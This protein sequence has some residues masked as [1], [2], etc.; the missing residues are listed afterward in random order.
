MC[1]RFARATDGGWRGGDFAVI[2]AHNR[3]M[4]TH[5][6]QQ[7]HA[8]RRAE[9][10]GAL[11]VAIDLGL[12]QPAEHMLRSVLIA[13]RL[14]E[15]ID[16]DTETRD[17]LYYTCLLMWIGCHA[18]SQEYARWF[19][20]DIAVR[21]DAYL[22][23]WSGLPF[24]GF[25][26]RN[27]GRNEPLA[28][29]AKTIA[30]FIGDARGHMAE[31]IHSH[32]ASA[33]L[34]AAHI[35]LPAS[36][37]HALGFTFERFDGRGLPAGVQG[38]QI[39]LAMRI[40]QLA[41]VCEVHLRRAGIPGVLELLH[42]R[43]GGQLDPDL[44]EAALSDPAGLFEQLDDPGLWEQVMELAP[45]ST[46]ELASDEFEVLLRG[47]GDFVDLKCPF[48]LGHARATARLA[49]AAA[50]RLG[51]DEA[52]RGIVR[53]AGYV[54]DVGRMG[55]SNLLWSKVGPLSAPD[56]ERVRM[57]PYFTE[58]ILER[59]PGFEQERMVARAHHERLDG[60]G[61]PWALPGLALG[62]PERLLAAAVCYQSSIERR[63]Y[64]EAASPS[65]AARHVT[66]LAAAGTLDADCV[67]AVIEASGQGIVGII[68]AQALT[69]REREVLVLAAM[70]LSN[71]QI[72]DQLVLSVKTVR[73][74]VEHCYAKI[75]VGNRVGASLYVLEHG[76][77]ARS[78]G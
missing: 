71:R 62:R 33:S 13:A 1:C 39:P 37:Q 57:H 63:P 43:R 72:A 32:C 25:L 14:S 30:S 3:D 29:R 65:Q 41:D 40:A 69:G 4:D 26:A 7:L 15:R 46:R 5:G 17:A 23:D 49:E 64:R 66:E 35:G 42:A 11:S 76:L 52:G 6:G 31:L 16:P 61:Y 51:L 10:L 78:G 70:G 55:V 77:L 18:D 8:V 2:Q 22:V 53:R 54:H 34:L 50:A 28:L 27:V 67:R 24:Y 45:D 74:H 56:W 58:R 73:N 12:G 68:P 59:I 20:D 21:H 60:C 44:V 47:I 9:V 19:G 48:T 38:A 36:V 75:G